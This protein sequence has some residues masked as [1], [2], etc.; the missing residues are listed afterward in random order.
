MWPFC[1]STGLAV[2]IPLG[3]DFGELD[4]AAAQL[5]L[6]AR[7]ARHVE[8]VLDEA[9]QV[10]RLPLDDP[11]LLLG[12]VDAAQ[13][14]QLER[15]EDRR[16]RIA[17][18]VAEHRQEFVL[19]ATGDLRVAPRPRQLRH[20]VD[21]RGDRVD[22]AV[23]IDDRLIDEVEEV[24]VRRAVGRRVHQQ[25]QRAAH[26]RLAGGPDPVQ[27]LVHALAGE[28]GQRL[29]QRLSDDRPIV[30]QAQIHRVGDLEHVLR[31]AEERH[32]DRRLFEHAGEPLPVGL[33]DGADPG[34]QQLG[35]HAG[36]QLP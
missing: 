9:D 30:D 32:G 10:P 12:G 20:V 14:Q 1:S 34:A 2:S 26:V 3:H 23:A 24:L 13:A 15:R 17:Q 28:L 5:H 31:S 19:G 11:P 8:Q 27:Q 16:E 35:F 36:D 22:L 7:D 4:G 25:A 18:L 29:A 21:D 6:S 33:F